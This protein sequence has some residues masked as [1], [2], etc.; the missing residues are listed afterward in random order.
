MCDFCFTFFCTF[1][2]EIIIVRG[3]AVV[4]R[5]AHNPEGVG[6]SPAPATKRKPFAKFAK[7]FF[8]KNIVV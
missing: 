5:R 1:A 4:A 3:R 7:G 2:A 6:S 8:I